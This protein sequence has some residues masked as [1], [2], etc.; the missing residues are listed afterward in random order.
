MNNVF[1]V[2]CTFFKKFISLSVNNT[3][4]IFKFKN[5]LYQ[6]NFVTFIIHVQSFNIKFK[7]HILITLQ[8]K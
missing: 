3:F 8:S 1:L 5:I 6:K 4:F 7:I 2:Y